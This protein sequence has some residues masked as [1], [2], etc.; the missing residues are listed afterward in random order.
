[1]FGAC[2]ALAG[3]LTLGPTPDAGAPI[4]LPL[5]RTTTVVVTPALGT[6]VERAVPGTAF[7][8]AAALD[9]EQRW[10]EAAAEYQRALDEWSDAARLRP[11]PALDRAIQKA[12]RERQRSLLLASTRPMRGRFESVATSINPLEEGRL[13]RAKVMVVRA[14]RG[15]APVD[16]TA[17][18]RAALEEALRLAGPSRG[19]A[20]ARLLLC[21]TRAAAGDHAGA[22][23][24]RARVATAERHDLDNALALAV[25]A[26]ALGEDAE[27]MARLEI[28]LLR[29]V[30][31]PLDPYSLRDLYLAND[32]DRLRGTPRFETLFA[33]ALPP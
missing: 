2:A 33:A 30:P 7:A 18:T 11:S 23:L 24:E 16:L 14:A 1:M 29:P 15:R 8:A 19:S 3:L 5:G 31:H 21:A 9:A 13:L 12:E 27:A 28:A 17:R 20:E 22:R 26:A 4:P 10:G 6:A 32:W 25:C